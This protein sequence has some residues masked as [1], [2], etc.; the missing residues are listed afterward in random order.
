MALPTETVSS[1][2]NQAGMV[3]G[4]PD[5][6]SQLNRQEQQIAQM[7]GMLKALQAQ[8]SHYEQTQSPAKTANTIPSAPA[9]TGLLAEIGQF[10]L[11]TC[12]GGALFILAVGMAGNWLRGTRHASDDV[13]PWHLPEVRQQMR[14][15]ARA[16]ELL[17]RQ[18]AQMQQG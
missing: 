8:Q 4:Q 13:V 17:A 5:L 1:K 15:R 9:S 11:S 7:G 18:V 12:L 3:K 6:R 14:Q 16:N 2:T 10:L